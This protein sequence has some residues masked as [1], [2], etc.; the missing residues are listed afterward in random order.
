MIFILKIY[1]VDIALQIEFSIYGKQSYHIH[2][3]LC[4]IELIHVSKITSKIS[5]K[6]NLTLIEEV[7]A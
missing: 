7:L 6:Y 4:Y 5:I 3:V 2:V 1:I